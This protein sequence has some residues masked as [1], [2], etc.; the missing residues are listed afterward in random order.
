M[1]ELG[2]L[3]KFIHTQQRSYKNSTLYEFVSSNFCTERPV[4]QNYNRLGEAVEVKFPACNSKE[5]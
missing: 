3:A 1:Q 5:N 2:A 4:V